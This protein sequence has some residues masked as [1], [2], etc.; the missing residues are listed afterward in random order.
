MMVPVFEE[1]YWVHLILLYVHLILF[2]VHLKNGSLWFEQGKLNILKFLC[3]VLYSEGHDSRGTFLV[4][5]DV[6]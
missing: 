6:C 5:L 3:F 1:S 4:R 2:Y